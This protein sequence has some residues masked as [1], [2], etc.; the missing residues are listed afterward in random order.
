MTRYISALTLVLMLGM[1]VARLT[2]LSACGSR[3]STW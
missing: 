2:C 3:H 1:V